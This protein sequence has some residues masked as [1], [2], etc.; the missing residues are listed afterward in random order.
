MSRIFFFLCGFG[1]L[2]LGFVYIILY[3][4]LLN[5]GYNFIDYVHFISRRIECYYVLIGL[6]VM[7]LSLYIKG[8]K[9]YGIHL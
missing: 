7:N 6:V 4:N 2:T 3:L 9:K 5:T 8:D 1:L